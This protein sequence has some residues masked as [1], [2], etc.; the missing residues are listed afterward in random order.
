MM[1]NATEQCDFKLDPKGFIGAIKELDKSSRSR[2]EFI[3]NLDVVALEYVLDAAN[4]H[5]MYAITK[6][7]NRIENLINSIIGDAVDEV[8]AC[9]ETI[10]ATADSALRA[11]TDSPEVIALGTMGART[12]IDA[13]EECEFEHVA[14]WAIA[15][16]RDNVRNAMY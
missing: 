12:A 4:E 10:E 13:L 11:Y 7:K 5:I 2:D 3:D 9:A 1:T 6:N 16:M 8:I 14:Y 15:A